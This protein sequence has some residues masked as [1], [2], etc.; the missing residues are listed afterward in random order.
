MLKDLIETFRD[1]ERGFAL[2][3]HD[4]REPGIEDLLRD[5]E[6]WCRS[7]AIELQ[8][9]VSA[10]AV[11]AAEAEPAMPATFRG[12]VHVKTIPIFR[13]TKLILEE[14]ERGMDYAQS[15]YKAAMATEFPD[16]ARLIVE[17]QYQRL[18]AIQNR[19]RLLR[20]RR[21]GAKG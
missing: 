13:D 8:E 18:L 17:R 12:W 3:S 20:N 11:S 21:S 16:A 9:Q 19:I 10:L 7:A 2:A 5:G 15:R 14:C 1:G 6:E 4:N